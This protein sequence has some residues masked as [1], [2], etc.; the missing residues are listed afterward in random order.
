MQPEETPLAALLSVMP[1]HDGADEQVDW[2]ELRRAWGVRFPSDYTAFMATYGGG[3][4]DDAFGV[5]TPEAPAQPPNGPVMGSM[6]GETAT[7]RHIWETAGG[8]DG[9]SGGP[10]SVIA[11]G[12]SCGADI[13]GWLVVDEDPDRW[14]VVVW[15]RHGRPNWKVYDC[16]MVEFL[17]RLFAAGFDRCPLSDASLWG[18]PAP[19][20]V[21]WREEQR[22]WESGV[23]PYTGEPDPYFGME[24]E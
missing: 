2:E 22:R 6:P 11:W 18:E 15:E 17:R 13:L 12:V 8:P 3:G 24:F 23:D 7:M 4:I 5:L 20:F 21:H 10:D 19:R 14:P 9:V 1:P 16:G